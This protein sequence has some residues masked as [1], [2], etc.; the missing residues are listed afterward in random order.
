[1]HIVNGSKA[2]VIGRMQA[3]VSVVNVIDL[4]SAKLSDSFW[5]MRPSVSDDN[6]FVAYV[7]VFPLH[8]VPGVSYEYLV[9]DLTATPEENRTPPN[10]GRMPDTYDVGWPVYPEGLLNTPGD[11]ILKDESLAHL[12]SSD[13]LFW[14]ANT[15]TFGFTDRWRGVQ[16]LVVASVPSGISHPRVTVK[17]LVKLGIVDVEK[18]KGISENAFQVSQI[19]VV[20]DRPE[21]LRLSFRSTNPYCIRRDTLDVALGKGLEQETSSGLLTTVGGSQ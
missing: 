17:P 9:Y 18:C 6:R 16:R 12:M 19:R 1:M 3:A 13:G 20:K 21:Y 10:K 5:C 8:F 2:A 7:K 4:S 11:N 15:R 14:L